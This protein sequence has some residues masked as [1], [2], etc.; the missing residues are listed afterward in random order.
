MDLRRQ[1]VGSLG[2]Q[3]AR[4]EL[5]RLRPQLGDERQVQ[6]LGQQRPALVLPGGGPGQVLGAGEPTIGAFNGVR[7]LYFVFVTQLNDGTLDLDV[8]VVAER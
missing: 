6:R 8:G 3:R 4:A 2:E 5:G 7:E 1:S